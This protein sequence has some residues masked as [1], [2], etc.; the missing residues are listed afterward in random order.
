MDAVT[1]EE[2]KRC[3]SKRAQQLSHH[4]TLSAASRQS[5]CQTGKRE[6]THA[7]GKKGK[8]QNNLA[9]SAVVAGTGSWVMAHHRGNDTAGGVVCT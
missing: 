9:T 2:G 7:Q 5:F 6:R 8:K 1:P 4:R 3:R